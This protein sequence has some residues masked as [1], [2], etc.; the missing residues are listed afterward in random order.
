MRKYLDS[1]VIYD[2]NNITKEEWLLARKSGIGGSDAASVVGLN[3]YK[4]AV[5][6]YI[7]K[8]TEEGKEEKTTKWS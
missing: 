7:D 6:V 2:T 5:S 3:P 8:T 4:S 1:I